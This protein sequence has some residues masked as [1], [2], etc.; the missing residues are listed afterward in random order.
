VL[1]ARVMKGVLFLVCGISCNAALSGVAS[2]ATPIVPPSDVA[3]RNS[4]HNRH[5]ND[6]N[7][8]ERGN[9]DGIFMKPAATIEMETLDT[10]FPLEAVSWHPTKSFLYVTN[11]CDCSVVPSLATQFFWLCAATPCLHQSDCSV[12]R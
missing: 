7:S 4:R 10:P 3:R 12:D 8:L 5:T 11:V 9:G 6:W 2:L 1:R